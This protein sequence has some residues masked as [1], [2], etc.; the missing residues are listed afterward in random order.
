MSIPQII[1][2][3]WLS[4]NPVPA[5]YQTHMELWKIKLP[6]YQFILWDTKRFDLNKTAWT[7]QAFDTGMYAYAS[8]YIRFFAVYSY[9]GIYL[10]MDMEIVKPFGELL[11]S[12]L[13]LAYENHISENLE[14]GCFGAVKSHEYIRKCMEYYE[15]NDFIDKEDM[16]K[17]MRMAASERHDYIDP[18]ISPEIMKNA[19]ECFKDEEY[20]IYPREYFTAKNIVTGA[21]E[22]TK[23]TYTVHHFA[24][25]YHSPEWR[26]N[27]D[28]EQKINRL[29][30][31]KT[32][33]SKIVRKIIAA[34]NR[35]KRMG[36]GKAAEYYIEK[37]I[38]NKKMQEKQRGDG[39]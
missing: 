18:V 28:T 19:L 37:Y 20:K 6:E 23:N 31:E 35:V 2:Y 11:D 27:R 36:P 39:A 7:R 24:T 25:Q 10:D 13:M 16:G 3:C 4:D 8:D 29:F 12:G 14:A 9:G 15:I 21:I 26:K 17:I 30:G 1:H 38:K 22:R 5:D 32:L 34:G 33:L